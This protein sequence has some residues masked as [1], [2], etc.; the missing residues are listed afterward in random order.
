MYENCDI[1]IFFLQNRISNK[2]QGYTIDLLQWCFI[3]PQ[4]WFQLDNMYY[5]V[6]V[7]EEKENIFCH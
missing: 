2:S 5:T 6:Q 1:I 3:N 4:N 7:T